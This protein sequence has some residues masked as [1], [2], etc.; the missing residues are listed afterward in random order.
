MSQNNSASGENDFKVIRGR[1]GS[2]SLYEITDSEL[3]LL[4]KGSPS[5]IYLNF[6]IFLSSIGF[7]FLVTL[8]ATPIAEI[9]TFT[10]F[11]VFTIIGLLGGFLLFIIWWRMRG[12]VSDVVHKIKRR[13]ADF[14]G[15]EGVGTE[16]ENSEDQ[17]E[18]R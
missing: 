10:T 3:D 5:S 8:L 13:I 16:P 9:K 11:L 15:S 6:A 17:G 4:E 18:S 12:E 7:S 2:V 14:D 1:V